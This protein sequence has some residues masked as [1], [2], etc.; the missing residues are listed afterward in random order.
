MTRITVEVGQG[1]ARYKVAV[2]AKSIG[3]ALEIVGRQYTGRDAKA[4]F[5]LNPKVF[6]AREA[7]ARVDG[8]NRPKAA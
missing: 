7:A 4:A 1:A 5:P 2:R 8:V 3:R 6:L